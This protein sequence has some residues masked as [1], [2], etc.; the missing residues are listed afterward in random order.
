MANAK[1]DDAD[2]TVTGFQR[3][4]RIMSKDIESGWM[5]SIFV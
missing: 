1:A 3:R 4:Q 5:C 2:I